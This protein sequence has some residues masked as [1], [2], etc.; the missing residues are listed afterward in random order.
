MLMKMISVIILYI[1]IQPFRIFRNLKSH[2]DQCFS[3]FQVQQ[4][5]L[6]T[7]NKN[8]NPVPR[9]SPGFPGGG[10]HRFSD[11]NQL[12]RYQPS[13]ASLEPRP[14]AEPI[15]LWTCPGWVVAT[16]PRA[17]TRRQRT[18]IQ[19]WEEQVST[20]SGPWCLQLRQ[21][22]PM[23]ASPPRNF[24]RPLVFQR[25]AQG[26]KSEDFKIVLFQCN[27][28][29]TSTDLGWVGM[30]AFWLKATLRW[31]HCLSLPLCWLPLTIFNL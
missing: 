26:S 21:G 17:L 6:V 24:C 30:T 16:V 1:G 5:D 4:N 3:N 23:S 19:V 18:S 7:K 15:P 8:K 22:C 28:T 9:S 10:G 31:L 29:R 14:Q 12:P 25:Q 20:V 11:Y 27:M 13:L 2:L